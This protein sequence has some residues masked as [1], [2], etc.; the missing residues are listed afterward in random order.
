MKFVDNIKIPIVLST[1]R[2]EIPTGLKSKI[3]PLYSNEWL[4]FISICHQSL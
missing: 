1:S 4:Y 3:L 2:D